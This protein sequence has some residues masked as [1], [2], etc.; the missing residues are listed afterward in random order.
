[1]SEMCVHV[2]VRVAGPGLAFIVY[3]RAVAMMPMPQVWSACFF[4]MI[5]LLGLDSEVAQL[6]EDQPLSVGSSRTHSSLLLLLLAVCGPGVPD[7]LA[8]GPLP[9]LP[10]QGPQAG[11]GAASRLLHLLPAGFLL[12][13]RGQLLSWPSP[14]LKV[15][16]S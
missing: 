9:Q 13:H 4:I 14:G 5:I 3:P 2:R 16:C 11:A 10:A 12:G 8:G 1:M 15:D 7:D 6:Q